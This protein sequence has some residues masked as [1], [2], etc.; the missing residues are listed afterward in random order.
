MTEERLHLPPCTPGRKHKPFLWRELQWWVAGKQPLWPRLWGW[1]RLVCS[2][3]P[4][5]LGCKLKVSPCRDGGFLPPVKVCLTVFRQKAVCSH[6][7]FLSQYASYTGLTLTQCS[8]E[9]HFLRQR[10]QCSQLTL[11]TICRKKGYDFKSSLA[12]G[13]GGYLAKSLKQ[14]NILRS[15]EYTFNTSL[16]FRSQWLKSKHNL[17]RA[18]SQVSRKQT[19]EVACPA[20]EVSVDDRGLSGVDKLSSYQKQ[21]REISS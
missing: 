13:A 8:L 12:S 19:Q 1:G 21:L 17:L 11:L 7:R 20:V 10:I 3:T 16:S 9:D 18:T 6:S 4:P 2:G 5:I 14:C 15:P